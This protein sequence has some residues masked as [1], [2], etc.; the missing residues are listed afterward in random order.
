MEFIDQLST[1][2]FRA[3]FQKC[4]SQRILNGDDYLDKVENLEIFVGIIF[5]II[6]LATFIAVA[7]TV[8][9]YEPKI[10]YDGDKIK[11]RFYK[12]KP[13]IFHCDYCDCFFEVKHML[14]LGEPNDEGEYSCRCP[15]CTNAANGRYVGFTKYITQKR[16]LQG[17]TADCKES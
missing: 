1:L 9:R 10:L 16:E 12:D 15:Q 17:V 8:Y 13:V 3:L 5:G 2:K 11:R 14:E 7:T 6:I 4:I